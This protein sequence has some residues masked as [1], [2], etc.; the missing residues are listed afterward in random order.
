MFQ[1]G[2][3]WNNFSISRLPEIHS[4]SYPSLNTI[5]SITGINQR[6]CNRPNIANTFNRITAPIWE[7]SG[8]WEARGKATILYPMWCYSHYVCECNMFQYS[9]NLQYATTFSGSVDCIVTD[10]ND[11]LSM[12]NPMLALVLDQCT[13]VKSQCHWPTVPFDEIKTT[14]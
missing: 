10:Y 5:M 13:T 4:Q 2:I 7:L 9:M 3:L 6:K 14:V 8:C 11:V 1:T 12:N